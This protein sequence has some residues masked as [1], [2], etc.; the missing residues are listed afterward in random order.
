MIKQ[1]DKQLKEWQAV[2]KKYSV[3]R[4]GWVKTMRMAL[5]MSVEQ[6]ANRLGVTRSRIT[7]FE[8]AEIHDAVTLRSLKEAANAIEC[9]LV[10]AIVP[11]NNSSLEGI[12]KKRAEQIAH[13]RI[14]RVAH[15][16][17]LEAQAVDVDVLKDQK[18]ELVK[19]LMEHLSKQL[20]SSQENYH[21]NPQ[22][23]ILKKNIEKKKCL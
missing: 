15:S 14:A 22:E 20:W 8:N 13:E 10:Y 11:K 6:L 9:E 3:P 17:A 19:N 16:M 1:L 4:V 12:I 21:K 5:G 2:S 7:Q 23:N 18:D